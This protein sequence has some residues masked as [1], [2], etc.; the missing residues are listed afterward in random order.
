MLD[1]KKMLNDMMNKIQ[2]IGATT[3]RDNANVGNNFSAKLLQIAS[4]ANKTNNLLNNLPENQAIAHIIGDVHQHDLDSYNLTTNC[5]H[6]DTLKLLKQGFNTGYGTINPPKRIDSAASLSCII[7][8]SAQNDMFGGQSHYNFDNDM[9]AFVQETRDQISGHISSIMTD[10]LSCMKS[11][12]TEDSGDTDD[13]EWFD[14]LLADEELV[15]KLKISHNTR[16]EIEVRKAIEQSMQIVVYNLNS[17]HSRAGS[18]VPFS[19]LNIGIPKTEDAALVCE[20]LL[21]EYNKGLGK[22]EQPIFPNIIFRVKDGI[23]KNPWDPYYYLFQLACQVA[24]NRMNPTFLNCD[25]TFNKVLM[26]KGILPATMGC[27]TAITTDINGV[28][29]PKSRGNGAPI[30]INLPRIGIE[31]MKEIDLTEH[32]RSLMNRKHILNVLYERLDKMLDFSKDCLLHRIDV[33]AE[34]KGKDLPFLTEHDMMTGLEEVGPEDS[35]MP[36]LK[37]CTWGIGFIGLAETM[38]CL[39]GKH[40]GEDSEVWE[41]AYGI[42]KHIRHKC[43]KY[44]EQYKLNFSCYATPAE[45]LSGRFVELDKKIFGLI[46]GVTNKEYYTNSF[47]I[48][49][50]YNISFKEKLNLEAPFHDLCNGGHISYIELDRAPIDAPKV[51]ENVVRYAFSKELNAGYVGINFGIR[52][53]KDCGTNHIEGSKCPTCKS[54]NIQGID[55]VTGYLSL[56]ERFTK[57]KSAEKKDRTKHLEV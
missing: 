19:T 57:G 50:G 44:K 20:L 13:Y 28:D 43:D 3:E 51:V 39:F 9:A 7:I 2:Q 31:T 38:T 45:G 56:D 24:G 1:K 5:L 25:S 10:T 34:L 26:D 49:V 30:T 37:H 8:Q 47:H 14:D 23:N 16:V 42:I 53:C 11:F 46:P 33:L 35:I 27:R 18:Q 41:I 21:K 4:I 22:G 54:Q 32:D 17:M 52:Y 29:T 55:R 6:I 40:H 36:M 15:K 48:P 12:V